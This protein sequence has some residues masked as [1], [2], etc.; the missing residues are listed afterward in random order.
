MSAYGCVGVANLTIRMR[1]ASDRKTIGPCNRVLFSYVYV[2]VYIPIHSSLI[3][4]VLLYLVFI[5][6]GHVFFTHSLSL[7]YPPLIDA[8]IGRLIHWCASSVPLSAAAASMM[9]LSHYD[10]HHFIN[11]CNICAC[12]WAMDIIAFVAIQYSSWCDCCRLCVCVCASTI[13][14]HRNA[15]KALLQ[16]LLNRNRTT[17]VPQS[18]DWVDCPNGNGNSCLNSNYVQHM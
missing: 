15:Y 18:T 5:R 13:T 3:L 11:I 9:A 14:C 4:Y 8:L 10:C 7:S 2:Y 16:P 6:L 12:V 17:L 1:E